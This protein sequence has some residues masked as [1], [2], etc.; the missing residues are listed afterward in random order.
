MSARTVPLWQTVLLRIIVLALPSVGAALALQASVPAIVAAHNAQDWVTVPAQLERVHDSS[1]EQGRSSRPFRVEVRYR[2]RFGE[3]SYRSEQLA[4]DDPL[5]SSL[6]A[7]RERYDRLA[8]AWRSGESVTAFVDPRHPHRAALS[9]QIGAT[10]YF[11][12]FIG[13]VLLIVLGVSIKI[14]WPSRPA[15]RA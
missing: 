14:M 8:R 12:A 4:F 5:P 10:T 13:L 9:L 6:G 15:A 1:E 7:Q 2:Y 11:V 3:R